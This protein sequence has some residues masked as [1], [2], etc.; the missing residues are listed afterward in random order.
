MEKLF[1]FPYRDRSYNRYNIEVYKDDAFGFDGT[2]YSANIN[3]ISGGN[4]R[5]IVIKIVAMSLPE[6]KILNS[7]GYSPMLR[8]T[9]LDFLH[10]KKVKDLQ[11]NEVLTFSRNCDYTSS[12]YLSEKN[13]ILKYRRDISIVASENKFI[14]ELM[15]RELY[16]AQVEEGNQDLQKFKRRCHFIDQTLTNAFN[17]L[18]DRDFVE[19]NPNSYIRLKSSGYQ[20]V[21]D[22][23]FLSPYRN[24]VFLI[25]ACNDDIYRLIDKVYRPIVEDQL[26]YELKFQE[27]SEPKET[28]HEDMWE[29]IEQSKLI[30]CDFTDKR[31]NCFIEYGYALRSRQNII[32]TIEESE[33]RNEE[34]SLKIPFDTLTQKFTFWQKKWLQPDYQGDEINTFAAELKE[35]IEKKIAM[36][37]RKSNI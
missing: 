1:E 21:E 37:E 4:I 26:G 10:G 28:I 23:F 25:A 24:T 17:V 15:L 9:L 27:K 29:S 35:R 30:L 8:D 18:K 33:G 19:H 11:K 34:G 7:N 5:T 16:K 6:G 36:L 32:L 13:G 3:N 22:N 12:L 20:F 2:Q 31:P 14:R